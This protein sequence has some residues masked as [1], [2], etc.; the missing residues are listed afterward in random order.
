MRKSRLGKY[1]NLAIFLQLR[2]KISFVISNLYRLAFVSP[3]GCNASQL[4]LDADITS[5]DDESETEIEEGK[6]DAVWRRV[7]RVER[8]PG[9]SFGWDKSL[10]NEKLLANLSI[11]RNNIVSY[12]FIIYF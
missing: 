4:D 10:A 5:A 1:N 9:L 7:H 11:D 6:G 8:S 2:P 3:D 12:Y